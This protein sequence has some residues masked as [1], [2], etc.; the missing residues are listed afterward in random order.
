MWKI[1]K[2]GQCESEFLIIRNVM[3]NACV[4]DCSFTYSGGH[5][6]GAG[7]GG[8]LDESILDILVTGDTIGKIQ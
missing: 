3:R 7:K 8:G 1:Y 5:L 2:Q 4:R 6:W